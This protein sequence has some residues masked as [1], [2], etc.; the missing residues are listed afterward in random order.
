[1]IYAFLVC[2]E[3][4]F[5]ISSLLFCDFSRALQPRI[6]ILLRDEETPLF[7]D[8]EKV[9]KIDRELNDELPVFYNYSMIGGYFNMP[10]ARMAK[11]GEFAIGAAIVKP[12]DIYGVNFQM[13]DRLEFSLNYRVY[14]GI[15]E[16]NFGHEG[17]GDDA[18]R[19]GNVKLGLLTPEDGFP[20]LP[21]IS[22]GVEDF[23]GTKRFNSKYVVATKEFLDWNLECSLGWGKGRIK[24]L[25]GGVAWSPFRHLHV[26]IL[27]DISF[28][29][30][31]MPSITKSILTN[32]LQ[33][34]RLNRGSMEGSPLSAGTLFNFP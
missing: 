18:E 2:G 30:N 13:F 16:R 20:F 8:L 11:S 9:K 22:I 15:T 6:P 27:K 4:F 1:M 17:F 10:S 5:D 24:E 12:Y 19:I 21:E 3:F 31:T 7:R 25:F 29:R 14:K 33:E 28:S 23:I 34:E 26:P 32:I